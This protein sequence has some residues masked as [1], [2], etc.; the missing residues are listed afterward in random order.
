MTVILLIIN[1]ILIIFVR[2]KDEILMI[3]YAKPNQKVGFARYNRDGYYLSLYT[4][5]KKIKQTLS[6]LSKIKRSF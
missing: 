3:N 2:C 1:V 6:T 5:L 4:V